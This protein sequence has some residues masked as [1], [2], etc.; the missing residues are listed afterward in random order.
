MSN[1]RNLWCVKSLLQMPV[2]L[3]PAFSF[4]TTSSERHNFQI[5]FYQVPWAQGTREGIKTWLHLSHYDFLLGCVPEKL[6]IERDSPEMQ[7]EHYFYRKHLTIKFKKVLSF[8]NQFYS[9]FKYNKAVLKQSGSNP[10]AYQCPRLHSYH[11]LDKSYHPHT[12]NWGFALRR[13]KTVRKRKKSYIF[14]TGCAIPCNHSLLRM[15]WQKSWIVQID[16]RNYIEK[17]FC[18]DWTSFSFPTA[19][20]FLR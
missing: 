14:Q 3:P 10:F 1:W 6:W 18:K 9:D 13:Q 8:E 4:F 20:T 19:A 16:Q 17:A 5:P 15:Y 2:S 12:I 11:R 7:T